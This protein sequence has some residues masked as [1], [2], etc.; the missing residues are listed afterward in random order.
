M[1][2]RAVF[3][4]GKTSVGNSERCINE[5]D[6]PTQWIERIPRH[7]AALRGAAEIAAKSPQ[8]LRYRPRFIVVEGDR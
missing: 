8:R 7:G 1:P 2:P 5:R 3:D 4:A 6:S